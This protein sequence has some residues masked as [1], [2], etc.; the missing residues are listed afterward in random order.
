MNI[1]VLS[2]SH[3]DMRPLIGLR[4]K[5]GKVDAV[6]HLGDYCRDGREA[7]A[8]LGCPVYT[9]RGNC[10][11]DCPEEETERLFSLG[12]K[13]FLLLHG[14]TCSS[15]E[16]LFYKGKE[17]AADAVLFGHTHVPFCFRREGLLLLNPGSLSCP[18]NLSS[19]GCALLTWEGEGGI[20]E[21]FLT[22]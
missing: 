7:G 13:R 12:G 16:A 14:H 1:C 6:F 21:T 20:T 19:A 2:D 11:R 8:Y 22:V 4:D 9:V 15:L 3:G 17:R 5:I 10:D 18:R